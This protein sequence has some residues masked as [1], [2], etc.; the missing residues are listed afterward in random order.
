M[1]ASVCVHLHVFAHGAFILA[2]FFSHKMV[3]IDDDTLSVF[4]PK[5]VLQPPIL[6][7]AVIQPQP[8]SYM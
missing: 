5:T 4:K 1:R 8:N 6:L 7:Q 3:V 2:L